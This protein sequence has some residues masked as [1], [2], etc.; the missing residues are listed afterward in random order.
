M[1]MTI[2][3]DD[4]KTFRIL[5][6]DHHNDENNNYGGYGGIR[7]IVDDYDVFLLDMWGVMHNGNEPYDGVHTVVQKLKSYNNNI[8]DNYNENNV[9]GQK[10]KKKK[11][12]ILSNSSKRK[13]D[14]VK[15]LQKLG[16]NEN[17]FDEI[18][19]SGEVAHHL[20][21]YLSSKTPLPSSSWVP[22]NIPNVFQDLRS[23]NDDDNKKE[24]Y[25]AFCFGSGDEDEIY[26]NSCGWTLESDN[27]ENANLIVCRGPFVIHQKLQNN[28][29]NSN[30]D[31]VNNNFVD[32]RI[33]GELYWSTYHDVLD[34]AARLQIPM[35]VCNPDKIRP[36]H[37]K[38]PMPGTIG[39]AYEELLL[40]YHGGNNNSD[41]G[42]ND[43][44]DDSFVLY[45][46]K[47]FPSV[48][49]IALSSLTTSSDD[50]NDND[51]DTKT[52]IDKSRVAMVGDALETDITGASMAGIDSIWVVMDGI[53][54]Q[55]I[56]AAAT[57]ANEY[58]ATSASSRK[59]SLS[60]TLESECETVLQD[61][62]QKSETTYAKGRRV[63]PTFVIPHFRW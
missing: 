36:D 22:K 37:D 45:L 47:P 26:L 31:D 35:V 12:I 19:T 20:L 44:S 6:N 55:H 58:N 34:Q 3:T 50:N 15:M 38:S 48:Y 54:N 41:N 21:K 25:K 24:T 17:D 62:N 60:S 7:S 59:S 27:I 33:N 1:V 13:T 29:S 5:G 57:I 30:V 18:I 51:D 23:R 52:S 4:E 63:S 32:K 2:S 14:S 53:H 10:K 28:D 39:V 11:L 46:G 16:F 8:N 9:D 43:L 61:F 40:K 42:N 49:E 56:I